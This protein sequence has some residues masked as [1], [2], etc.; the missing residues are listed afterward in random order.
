MEEEKKQITIYTDG[1]CKGNPGEGGWG[2]FIIINNTLNKEFYGY[3]NNTT[4][5]RMELTAA[6]EALKYFKNSEELEVNTDSN[7]LKQGITLWIKSWKK[8]NWINKQKKPV[9]NLDLWQK[10]DFLNTT[11]YFHL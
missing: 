1:A 5:N 9:K 6:I 3:E 4:N 10:L 2:V 11:N 7:Y 8:S